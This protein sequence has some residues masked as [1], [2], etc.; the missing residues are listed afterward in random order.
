MPS[1]AVSSVTPTMTTAVHAIV[2]NAGT[3]RATTAAN[4]GTN[5]MAVFSRNDTVDEAA[6]VSDTS[7]KPITTKNREPSSNPCRNVRRSTA[8]R[9][10][11][12][13]MASNA[14]AIRNRIAIRVKGPM[15][16]NSNLLNRYAVARAPTTAAKSTA[17]ARA[18]MTLLSLDDLSYD[19]MGATSLRI[20]I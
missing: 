17:A 16:T 1:P 7:S 20:A 10:R 13:T 3:R 4:R 12:N 15:P 6:R 8:R 19:S 11:Q 18:D 9:L 14:N 5:T 2:F